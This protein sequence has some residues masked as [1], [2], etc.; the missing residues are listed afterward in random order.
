MDEAALS[1][2]MTEEAGDLWLGDA[3]AVLKNIPPESV[4]CIVTSPPYWGLRDYGVLGQIGAEA[5]LSEYLAKLVL[6]F[7]ECRR[8][9]K[10]Q[11][12]CWVNMGDAYARAGG[13]SC[14]NGRSVWTIATRAF[15]GAHF[16]TFPEELPRRCIVAGCPDKGVVLDPFTGSG[17][18]LV[19]AKR[20][21][22][23]YIGVDIQPAYLKLTAERLNTVLRGTTDV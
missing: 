6:V 8:V 4:D 16:A 15:K 12:T 11:G 20:L 18:T 9:L 23:R 19:V 14:N 13:W 5:A 22:R 17:T 3:L 21:G 1:L 2:M 10:K 7:E